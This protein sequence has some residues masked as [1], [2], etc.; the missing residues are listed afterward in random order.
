ME[1]FVNN[2][3]VGGKGKRVLDIGSYNVNGSYRTLFDNIDIEYVGL[4]I[5]EGPNVD[6]VADKLY[7]WDILQD[8]SFDYIISGQAFEHI[9]YPWLTMKEIYKKLKKEGIVCIIAPNG[10][11]EHRYPVDCYRYYADG[12]RALAKWGGLKILEVNVGGVPHKQVSSEWDD[13]WNDVDVVACKSRDILNKYADKK[14]FSTER[15]YNPIHNM[16][17]QCEF[18]SNW[19]CNRETV[20]EKILNYIVK[21]EY[22]EICIVG[23]EYIGIILEKLLQSKKINYRVIKTERRVISDNCTLESGIITDLDKSTEEHRHTLYI[24]TILETY[25]REKEI[26]DYYNFRNVVYL[27]DLI[28]ENTTGENVEM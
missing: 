8:E 12:M 13:L 25:K 14:M 10:L 6:V 9:E 21:G 3:V 16:K 5:E 22:D 7:S 11:L 15:R 27:D 17:L 28:K 4:D 1:S 23:Y 18:I 24:L 20:D 26:K 2:Y 19:M